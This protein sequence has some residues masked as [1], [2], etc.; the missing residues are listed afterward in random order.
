MKRGVLV[1][2]IAILIPWIL[3]AQPST[4]NEPQSL[5]LEQAVNF[6][7]E[8]NKEL[9][10]SQ[11]N[12]ELRNKMVT[13]AVSQGLPQVTGSLGYSTNFGY[14]A[15]FGEGAI[16]MKDQANV[17]VSVSQLLFSGEWILG[18]QTSKIAKQMAAQQVDIT[19]LDIKETVYNSYY[20]ILASER[21]ME[22]VKVNLEN[23]NKI[24]NHTENM[25]KAGTAEITDVDQ[26]RITVGQ[27]K[28]SLLAM[29]RTVDVNYNL[30]RL[31][32]GLQAGT[33]ITLT[34]P[35]ENFLEEGSFLKL[36]IQQF[37]V[38]KNSQYQ[39][40]QTQEELQK[41]MVG[42]KKWAYAPTISGSYS[43]QYQL[44]KGGFMNI[45]NSASITMSIPVFSGLQRKAQLDQE[46]ITLEQT[47]LNKSLLED[48]LNL[49][50]E[51]YK[52]AL[53]NAM[54]DYQLQKENILVAKKVL[55][56]YQHKYNA[57]TVS[58]LDLTQ[59]NNN[60][61]TAENNYTSACLTLL[62]AQTQLEKL[63][64]ELK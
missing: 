5:S 7:V 58:S 59:A 23:M 42:L 6:A 64:N 40:M 28:N 34:D 4:P 35:L 25:Y 38:N 53:K 20:T 16:K 41:K 3:S 27:L 44:K 62:Q 30:L 37:D 51:Q 36:A 21:L 33:P 46:K 39:L 15:S 1:T 10:V 50:E 32:L 2:F 14:E 24:Q 29:Q 17:S 56:N 11:M 13:E 61:L 55:E 45:P 60:Y 43:Y 63:Y 49:Q 48:Q 9:Q 22:I 12:I 47:T 18:I 52:F 19:E 8:H 26:I 54:E 57:G 31:Q